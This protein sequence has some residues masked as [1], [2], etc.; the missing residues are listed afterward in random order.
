MPFD[1]TDRPIRQQYVE[2]ERPKLSPLVVLPIPLILIIA[3]FAWSGLVIVDKGELAIL[4]RKTGDN[5]PSGE[6][7]AT[8]PGQKGIQLDPLVEG[9]YWKNPYTWD[10]RIVQQTKVPDESL[11]VLI[12]NYGDPLRPGQVIAEESQRGI[13]GDTKAPGNYAI[14]TLAYTIETHPVINIPAGFQGVVTRESGKQ[15]VNPNVFLVNEGERGVQAATVPPGK[16]YANPYVMSITPVDIRSHR[17]DMMDDNQISFPS[18]DGFTIT[19]QGTIEW[20][21]DPERAAEVFVKYVDDRDPITCV[22]DEIILPNARAYSR[23]EGSRHLARDFIRGETRQKFQERFEEGLKTACDKQGIIIMSALVRETVPPPEIA[24]PI[25]EREIAVQNLSKYRTQ[26]DREREQKKLSMEEKIKDR[27]TMVNQAQ[28]DVSVAVTKAN[29]QKEVALI[30]A[31]RMLEVAKLELQ[32]AENQ[33]RAKVAH[34]EAEADVIKFNNAAEAQGM[35]DSVAA[36]GDGDTYVR[37]LLNQK[38]APSLSYILAN[39][40]GAFADIFTAIVNA[41]KAGEDK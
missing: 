40:D 1:Q 22:V 35:R 33:A 10:F 37:Y 29:Q 24:N 6:I 8:E 32:A 2:Q 39:T 20:H 36:F 21:I 3:F 15:P 23:L 19:M 34:G 5:L 7:I 30:E 18:V 9:W 14:N 13:V 41:G 28:A 11:A 4:I 17:F 26:Q 27:K 16:Y 25:K 31:S 38:I 12:R